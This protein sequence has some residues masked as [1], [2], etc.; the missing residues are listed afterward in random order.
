MKLDEMFG[1]P[2]PEAYQQA[3]TKVHTAIIDAGRIGYGVKDIQEVYDDI[4]DLLNRL[5]KQSTDRA[6]DRR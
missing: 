6:R 4:Q 1:K 2:S 3:M 5:R